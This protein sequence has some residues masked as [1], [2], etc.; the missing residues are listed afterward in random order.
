MSPLVT[1]ITAA[2][3]L[4]ARHALHRVGLEA[5]IEGEGEVFAGG[6]LDAAEFAHHPA[7]GADLDLLGAG[8][9]AEVAL[10]LGLDAGLA[11]LEARDL[12]DRV[13][14]LDLGEV[15]LGDRADV[16]DDVRGGRAIGV[17]AAEADLGDHAGQERGVGG[18]ADHVVPAQVL[19]DDDRDEGAAAGHFLQRAFLEVGG[20]ID[21]GGEAGQHRRGVAGLLAHHRDAVVLP[22]A[23]EEHALAVEDLAAGGGEQADVDAVFLGEEAVAF[24]LDDLQ[25]AHAPGERADHSGLKAE[26]REGAAGDARGG[27]SCWRVIRSGLGD[28]RSGGR[29]GHGSAGTR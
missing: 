27:V 14:V 1:S 23:G 2:A 5:E 18:D 24:V 29:A 28:C 26:E 25:V 19:G 21:Q 16:A 3:E 8:V 7:G 11:D 4:S 13:G 20:K 12:Q 10:E 6:A 9:A 22:V 15:G 17:E